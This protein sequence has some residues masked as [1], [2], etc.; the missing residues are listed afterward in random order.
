M[1]LLKRRLRQKMQKLIFMLFEPITKPLLWELE[2]ANLP[3]RDVAIANPLT[4]HGR[5]FFSQNDED[6]ILLE[7]LRR[8]EISGPSVFLEFGVDDGTECN[9]IILLALGWRGVWVGGG[10]LS[11][12]LP[13]EKARLKF[14]QRWIKRD[15]AVSLARQGLAAVNADL[16]DVRMASVDL[17]GNDGPIVRALLAAGVAP[18]VFIVEYNAKFP[19]GVEFEMP[20]DE[21]HVWQGDDY[22]GVSLQSWTG[23][24]AA[25][26]SLVACNE[27]GT[28]AF[29][30][31][32]DHMQR[33]DDVPKNIAQIYRIGHYGPY[34][35]SGHRTS[36][37]TVRYLATRIPMRA[38]E[39]R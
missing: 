21:K 8:L 15:N 39:P 26:Y 34:A 14:V 3:H 4:T 6:G 2:R 27:N 37:R 24:F 10:T 31:K 5:K 38:P 1:R 28:N 12:D 23:I 20:Y 36:P 30:V 19:P 25:E 35:T 11:F 9:T 22:Q 29:F 16:R 18:D 33:F 32:S 13:Q 7:I 17:D